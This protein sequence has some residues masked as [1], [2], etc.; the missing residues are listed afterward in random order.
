[1]RKYHCNLAGCDRLEMNSTKFI[2]T[3]SNI[4]SRLIRPYYYDDFRLHSFTILR[5]NAIK[6]PKFLSNHRN[7]RK[8]DRSDEFRENK[9]LI[10]SGKFQG[11][12]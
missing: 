7:L 3:V 9:S 5:S 2:H 11:I 4:G 8:Y 6:S 1:M 12:N 10:R